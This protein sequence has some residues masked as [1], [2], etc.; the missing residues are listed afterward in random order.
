MVDM[1][2]NQT[3]PTTTAIT[4]MFHIIIIKV[5]DIFIKVNVFNIQEIFHRDFIILKRVVWLTISKIFCYKIN[6][7][8][9]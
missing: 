7:K 2:S 1:P 5:R 3:E 9:I 8:L 4:I 6:K